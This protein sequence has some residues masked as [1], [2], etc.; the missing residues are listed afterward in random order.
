MKESGLDLGF[1]LD[2]FF[3]KDVEHAIRNYGADLQTSLQKQ[4]DPDVLTITLDHEEWDSNR[5]SN[6]TYGFFSMGQKF[7][8]DCLSIMQEFVGFSINLQMFE[9]V[10]QTFLMFV[11][12]FTKGF[13]KLLMGNLKKSDGECEIFL[14][15]TRDLKVFNESF[16]PS[17]M[18]LFQKRFNNEVEDFVVLL[19]HVQDLLELCSEE[20]LKQKI[21]F[22]LDKDICINSIDYSREY[23]IGNDT[24]PSEWICIVVSQVQIMSHQLKD[25]LG[26]SVLKRPVNVI[27]SKF[28]H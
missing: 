12:V 2:N 9:T 5:I 23:S 20:Y 14:A 1:L 17:I 4:F 18:N 24:R 6:I 3:S 22:L 7:I 15:L 13:F 25:N 28:S 27:I 8:E 11:E 26:I 10:L 16:L 19:K 21:D